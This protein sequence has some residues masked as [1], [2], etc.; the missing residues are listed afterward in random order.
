MEPHERFNR[1]MA[2][3]FQA[4]EI[5]DKCVRVIRSVESDHQRPAA[6]AY[7][8]LAY[9]QMN[10]LGG[11]FDLDERQAKIRAVT[12]FLGGRA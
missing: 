1:D 12:S 5:L 2:K 9:R 10:R 6:M 3:R 11:V 8:Q 4:N 7:V